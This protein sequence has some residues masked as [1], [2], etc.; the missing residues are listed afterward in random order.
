MP[1]VAPSPLTVLTRSAQFL[2]NAPR[3]AASRAAAPRASA[4]RAGAVPSARSRRRPAGRAA[5]AGLSLVQ[6][7][8]LVGTTV[9]VLLGVLLGGRAYVSAVMGPEAAAPA[10]P[11]VSV[12]TADVRDPSTRS[13]L[14]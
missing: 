11:V 12:A 4:E 13:R 7:L 5:L 9:A 8:A 14:A 3:A 6:A 10:T 2:R 1:A